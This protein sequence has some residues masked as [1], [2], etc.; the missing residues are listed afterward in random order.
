MRDPALTQ[1]GRFTPSP[2][3]EAWEAIVRKKLEELR[4][5]TIHVKT[6]TLQVT[7]LA[8]LLFLAAQERLPAQNHA[9]ILA[10]GSG[11]IGEFS[12]VA[13]RSDLSNREF[14]GISPGVEFII[15]PQSRLSVGIAYA[16][17]NFRDEQLHNAALDKFGYVNHDGSSGTVEM[18]GV[19]FAGYDLTQEAELNGI[20]SSLYLNIL[21]R[22]VI[23][24]FVGGGAGVGLGEITNN[25]DYFAHPVFLQYYPDAPTGTDV[26]KGRQATLLVKGVGGINIFLGN[27][28]LMRVAGGYLNGGH[29][30]IGV[31]VAF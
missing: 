3:R 13:K 20:V 1:T 22:G 2:C 15:N 12:S 9:A 19:E 17:L 18:P 6:R 8:V 27:N 16:R 23:R 21:T 31:G 5:K 25:R 24:P 10:I 11:G 30:E 4:R 7:F 26:S 14:R 29:A 28:F